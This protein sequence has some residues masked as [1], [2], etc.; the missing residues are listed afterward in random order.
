MICNKTASVAGYDTPGKLLW[1]AGIDETYKGMGISRMDSVLKLKA[2]QNLRW[3]I[4][5]FP[6]EKHNSVRLKAMYDGIKFSYSGYT[7]GIIQFH[8]MNG[9]LLKDKPATIF[10]S[11]AILK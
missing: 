8:P 7:T 3:K 9:I 6:N 10:M 1:I 11:I 4:V 5:T 2:P